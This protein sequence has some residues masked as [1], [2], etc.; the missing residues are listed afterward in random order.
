MKLQRGHRSRG[1][2]SHGRGEGQNFPFDLCLAPSAGLK[3]GSAFAVSH[4]LCRVG[5]LFR[6]AGENLARG[7]KCARTATAQEY[8]PRRILWEAKGTIC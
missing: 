1:S 3:K 8:F 4:N 7:A 5:R 2:F 6:M